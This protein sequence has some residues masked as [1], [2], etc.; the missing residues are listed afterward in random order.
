MDRTPATALEESGRIQ[1]LLDE[2]RALSAGPAWERIEE[3][4]QRLLGL[5]GEGLSRLLAYAR[6]CGADGVFDEHITSDELLSSLLLLHGLHPLPATERVRRA[7]EELRPRLAAHGVRPELLAIEDGV[8]RVRLSG[9]FDGAPEAV[10]RAL[11]DAA[12]ELARV[13]IEE[14]V[15][16]LVALRIAGAAP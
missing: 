14:P 1:Q 13:E 11:E 9:Q 10:R 2:V 7:L 3:L 5:Q 16:P 8:A 15:G 12:P 4:V 6:A